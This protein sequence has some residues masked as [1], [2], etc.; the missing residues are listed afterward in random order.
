M[1][2]KQN[3]RTLVLV[4][5]SLLATPVALVDSPAQADEGQCQLPTG[6]EGGEV[7]LPLNRLQEAV[8]VK[9]GKWRVTIH[10]SRVVGVS[11]PEGTEGVAVHLTGQQLQQA[12]EHASSANSSTVVFSVHSQEW[13]DEMEERLLGGFSIQFNT[14]VCKYNQPWS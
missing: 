10:R 1:N 3:K 4:A 6:A 8:Q 7:A 11:I 2:N 9:S 13:V 14:T 12:V 5:A